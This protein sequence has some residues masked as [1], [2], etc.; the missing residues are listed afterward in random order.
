MF[1]K[2]YH[3]DLYGCD[4]TDSLEICYRFLEELVFRLNMT[5][6]GT[7]YLTHGL[8][9]FENGDRIEMF[10]EKAGISGFVPLVESGI[11]IH[12]LNP[13]KFITLDVYSCKMFDNFTVLNLAKEYFGYNSYEEHA[14]LRGNRYKGEVSP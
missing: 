1:G 10:P 5:Q 8:T 4:N 12:T 6:A 11:S 3:L 9:K 14:L 7:I 2:S 13:S